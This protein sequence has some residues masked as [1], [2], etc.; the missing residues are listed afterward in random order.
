MGPR[1]RVVYPPLPHVLRNIYTFNELT[2]T[3]LLLF[4]LPF[5]SYLFFSFQ[6]KKKTKLVLVN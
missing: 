3:T 4:Q 1:V 5:K 2:L 6:K